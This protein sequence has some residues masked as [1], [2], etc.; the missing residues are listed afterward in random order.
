MLCSAVKMYQKFISMLKK[1][2]DI[3]RLPLISVSRFSSKQSLYS[4]KPKPS[5]YFQ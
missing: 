1:V 3:E 2:K 5:Y 4:L